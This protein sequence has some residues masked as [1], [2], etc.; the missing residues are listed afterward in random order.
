MEKNAFARSP[1][2]HQVPEDTVI[3]SSNE[4]TSGLTAT[5]ESPPGKA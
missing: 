3:C 1:A 2:A 4:T 5:T